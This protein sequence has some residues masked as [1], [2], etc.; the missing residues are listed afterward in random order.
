MTN[1]IKTVAVC[2]AGGTMGAGIA[3]WLHER[4]LGLSPTTST[5]RRSIRLEAKQRFSGNR[6]RGK[7]TEEALESTLF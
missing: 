7:M 6:S 1:T 4:G 3:P 2:G 5:K